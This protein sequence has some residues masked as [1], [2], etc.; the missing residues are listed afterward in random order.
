MATYYHRAIQDIKDNG[1][2]SATTIITIA[3]SIL[4]VS[5]FALF[6]TNA[7]DIMNYWGKGVRIMAYLKPDTSQKNFPDIKREIQGIYGVQDVNF[8]SKE[9]AFK[10]LKEQMKR[11]SSILMNLNENPLPD[12]FEIRMTASSQGG[13]KVEEIATK[14]ESLPSIEDVEY[15]QKWLERFTNI[16]DLFRLAGYAMGGIFFMAA[17][18]IVANTIRLVIYTRREEIEIMR[19]VGAS[20][21]FIKSPFYIEGIIQGTLGGIIGIAALF[22]TFKLISSSVEHSFKY[23]LLNIRFLSPEFYCG[24][25]LCSMF[26]GWLGCYISLKQFLKA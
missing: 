4:I 19:L 3:L 21:K 26:V 15:G 2:L 1:F 23:E 13:E 9:E 8:I 18:F 7:N 6:F 20:E 25:I 5:A 12:A 17:V 11:Q 22:I 24:I 16:F 10:R 14:I